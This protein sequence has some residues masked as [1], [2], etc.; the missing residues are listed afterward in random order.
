MNVLYSAS[1]ICL[2]LIVF[3]WLTFFDTKDSFVVQ[4]GGFIEIETSYLV[5]ALFV[6]LKIIPCSCP[7]LGLNQNLIIYWSNGI[8]RKF[9]LND[10]IMGVYIDSVIE[11]VVKVPAIVD[12]L[13]SLSLRIL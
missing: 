1:K 6:K 9:P 10:L 4:F 13:F 11:V 7:Y 2:I 8:S 5:I 12:D 3:F